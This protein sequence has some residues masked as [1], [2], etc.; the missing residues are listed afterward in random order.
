MDNKMTLTANVSETMGM[1]AETMDMSNGTAKV[2]STV[3]RIVAPLSR[4]YSHV[5]GTEVSMRQTLLLVNAQVAFFMTVFPAD[6]HL[7]LRLG[8]LAWLISAVIKCRE[9]GIKAE[10]L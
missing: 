4:Y 6:C 2:A 10:Q 3:R 1:A 9:S 8:C 7:L 5:L